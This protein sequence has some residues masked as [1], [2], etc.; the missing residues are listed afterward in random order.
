MTSVSS[1]LLLAKKGVSKS[2]STSATKRKELRDWWD[3]KPKPIKLFPGEVEIY[4]KGPVLV[5]D[6]RISHI[7]PFDRVLKTYM[8]EHMISLNKDFYHAS[9]RTRGLCIGLIIITSLILLFTIVIDLLDEGSRLFAPV[10]IPLIISLVVG[11][12]VWRDMRP[13]YRIEWF[14][15]DGTSGGIKTEPLLREWL[16][17]NNGREKFMDGL[18]EAMNSAIAGKAWWPDNESHTRSE[19]GR[20]ENGR[21]DSDLPVSQTTENT[22]PQNATTETLQNSKKTLKLVTDN[23]E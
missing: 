21:S 13:K 9:S 17:N 18:V 14:M 20:S 2:I 23:Y 19:N 7:D 4:R 6:T 11:L 3:S 12:I 15:R 16:V 8:F 1:I 22:D 5:T 10:Y